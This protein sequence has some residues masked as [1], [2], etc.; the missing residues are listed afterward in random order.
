MNTGM[1]GLRFG[2]VPRAVATRVVGALLLSA[3]ALPALAA[4]ASAGGCGAC[5]DDGDGLTNEQEY[6]VYG[7]DLYS[8]DTDGDGF[9]DG[10]EVS[11]GQSPLSPDSNPNLSAGYGYIDPYSPS[12]EPNVSGNY[13]EIIQDDYVEPGSGDAD[14]DGLTDGYEGQVSLTDMYNPDTDGDGLSDSVE[15]RTKG[16][17]PLRADSEGDGMLDNCD[18][19]PWVFDV[20]DDSGAEGALFGGAMGCSSI[21]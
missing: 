7:T 6:A 16:T 5:D 21:S 18:R 10:Y 2:F 15:V 12:I 14:G 17:D 4:G 11:V 13:E 9:Y 3:V 20:D 1:V 8:P 19:N